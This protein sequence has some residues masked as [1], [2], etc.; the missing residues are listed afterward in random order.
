MSWLER[1]SKM[2]Q[3]HSVGMVMSMCCAL[4][5]LLT[6]CFSEPEARLGSRLE[7]FLSILDGQERDLLGAGEYSRVAESLKRRLAT[8]KDLENRYRE[9]LHEENIEF[10]DTEHALRFFDGSM[11]ARAKL[12]RFV[13]LLDKEEVLAFNERRFADLARSLDRRFSADPGLEQVYRKEIAPG[14]EKVSDSELAADHAIEAVVR[15]YAELYAVMTP[16]ERD[17]LT[18]GDAGKACRQVAARM[19]SEPAVQKA[20]AAIQA[21]LPATRDQEVAA[22]VFDAAAASHV[23]NREVRKTLSRMAEWILAGTRADTGALRA[24]FSK[25]V[26]ALAAVLPGFEASARRQMLIE[27]ELAWFA[28]VVDERLNFFEGRPAR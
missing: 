2:R 27:R 24:A 19:A 16:L 12:F 13:A 26:Q 17:S 21:R 23:T 15:P 18:Q 8:S 25:E 28:L 3:Q 22:M 4:V 1:E 6:G 11:R 20:R 10:F 5:A 7:R 14:L 9:V